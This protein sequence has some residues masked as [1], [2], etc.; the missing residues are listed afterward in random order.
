VSRNEHNVSGRHDARPTIAYLTPEAVVNPTAMNL[1]SGVEAG[2]RECDLNLIAFP[3]GNIRSRR[4]AQANIIYELVAPETFAGLVTWAAALQHS[5]FPDET[6]SDEELSALHTRYHPLPIVTLSKA[7]PGH[8][9]ALVESEQG[10]RDAI[11][12]LIEV[13]GFRRIAFIRGPE[14]HPAADVRYRAYLDA[15]ADH[16][17][18]VN[19]D[20]VTPPG[21]FVE[22]RGTQAVDLFLDQRSMRPKEDL[23]AIVAASDVFALTAMEAL[24]RRGIRVPEDVAVVGFNDSAEARCASPSLTSV[25]VPFQEQGRQA[26]RILERL[27]KGESVPDE[28]LVPSRLA[29]HQSCGCLDATVARAGT[30]SPRVGEGLSLEEAFVTRRE[31]IVRE[32]V[33][34][35]DISEGPTWAESVL[36]AFILDLGESQPGGFLTALREVLRGTTLADGVSLACQNVLSVLQRYAVSYEDSP[37]ALLLIGQA[38]TMLGETTS[39]VF[40]Q[41]QLQTESRVQTLHAITSALITTFEVERLVDVLAEGLPTLGIPSCYLALYED[42]QPYLYPQLAPEW[43]RLILA[44]DEDGRVALESGGKRFFTRHILPQGMLLAHRRY[45]MVLQPLYFQDAQI[46]FV[47]FEVGPQDW[48]VYEVLRG[49][50]ASALQGALLVQRV[51]ERSAEL[52]RQQYVLDTFMEN[53]PDR[54]YFKDLESRITRANKAHAVKLGLSDPAEEIGGSDFDFFPEEQARVKYEQEQEIIRTGQPL[55]NLE[56]SDG[57]GHWA[58]TTKMPLRDEHG[59]IIG[60]F[61]I[62]RDIT[63]MKEA[64]A[65]LEKA[66]AEIELQVAERTAELEREIE[67]RQRA[68][69]ESAHLQQEVIEAQRRAIQELSTP[70]IPVLVGVIVMPLIGSIDTMRARDVT[71]SLLAGIREHQARVVIIDIT[72][73]PIVDSGVA[74]YLNKTVQAARLKGARTIVTGISEAVAETIVDLGIDWSGIETL[75]DLRTGLQSVLAGMGVR[76]R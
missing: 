55:L 11:A 4:R 14:T 10:M 36:D 29:I 57:M 61:G 70:I 24:Q 51:R 58:L 44:Y 69:E 17:I 52:A 59:E 28:T 54:V 43:S 12:H 47:L 31:T 50:I 9:A 5:A 39:R 33:Q 19:A 63:E 35:M 67:E 1:W 26:V 6:L 7:V 73:V 15:L 56:E 32:M 30:F 53:V 40:A 38:R 34:A 66:Y 22:E 45:T 60:T 49:E 27:L 46:G 72:G 37:K 8:P 71:R 18:E 75:R 48:S 21:G 16:G 74:A 65:A 13:H 2:A 41:R 76:S 25:I 20:L 42:P 64:Q 3:G 23:E 68:Q 62:S